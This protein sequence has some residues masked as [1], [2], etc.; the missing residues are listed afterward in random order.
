MRLRRL[1]VGLIV[2]AAAAGGAFWV[3]TEPRPLGSPPWPEEKESVFVTRLLSI[4]SI[5][6]LQEV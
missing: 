4:T 3:L 6:I 1:I 5:K 2:L